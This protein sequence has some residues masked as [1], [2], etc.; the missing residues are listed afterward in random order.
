MSWTAPAFLALAATAIALLPVAALITRWRR[1]QMLRLA[2][3]RVWRRWLGGVPATGV[4]RVVL[5]LVAAT[6]AGAGAA[7]PHWGRP[8][9]AVV[10]AV[11]VALAVDVSASMRT[12]DVL[13]DRLGRAT[14]LVQ[15][16]VDRLPAARVALTVGAGEALLLLPLSA[17]REALRAALAVPMPPRGMA[18]G[19]NLAALL[20]TAAGQLIGGSG[21][22]VVLLASDGEE[23]VGEAARVADGL[24]REGIAVVVLQCGSETGG[25]VPVVTT[26]GGPSYLRD[27]SGTLVRSRARHE[28]LVALAGA[29]AAVIDAANPAAASLVATRLTGAARLAEEALRPERSTPFTLAAALVA[30]AA[31]ATWPWRRGIGLVLT[32]LALA[33]PAGAA[34]DRPDAATWPRWLPGSWYVAASRGGRDLERGAL[35]AARREFAAAST[36]APEIDAVELGAVSAAA[37]SGDADGVARLGERCAVTPAEFTACYNLGVANLLAG[38]ARAA[39]GALRRAVVR[40]PTD[41]DAWRNLEIALLRARGEDRAAG[42]AP[43]SP[44]ANMEEAMLAS[45]ARAALQPVPLDL[46]MRAD[47]VEKPW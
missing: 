31:F 46:G 38:D 36:L 21:G 29:D 3:P 15:R 27:T 9:A 45:A 44:A 47:A 13:P 12:A 24:R 25:P 40:R 34:E 33:A 39:V 28:A 42:G 5:L 30:S 17:D 1:R 6:L 41:R 18:A 10:P 11:D 23:H 8:A 26:D 2:T 20:A 7:R 4:G 22:R 16:A 14:E 19:S 32:A 35:A 43:R 37:L